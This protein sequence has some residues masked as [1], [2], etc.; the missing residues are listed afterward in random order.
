MESG[1]EQDKEYFPGAHFGNV[2][3]RVISG[4]D[5]SNPSNNEQPKLN[6]TIEKTNSMIYVSNNESKNNASEEA[7]PKRG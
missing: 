5:E 4:E 3:L 7:E 1:A 6:D 2:D